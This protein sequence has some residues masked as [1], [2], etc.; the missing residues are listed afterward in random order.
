MWLIVLWLWEGTPSVHKLVCCVGAY[1]AYCSWR[2]C[3][4]ITPCVVPSWE[5]G[6][7]GSS[8]FPKAVSS[9]GLWKNFLF[10]SLVSSFVERRETICY[11]IFHPSC[12][13]VL[14]ISYFSQVLSIVRWSLFLVLG[15]FK[16]F[17]FL[18]SFSSG[19]CYFSLTYLW[20]Y[21]YSDIII[22]DIFGKQVKGE[23]NTK[24]DWDH[25]LDIDVNRCF[26][27]ASQNF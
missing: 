8:W 27:D 5:V 12:L 17:I 3:D 22:V 4:D 9:L 16:F 21:F 1:S 13:Q 15:W 11:L 24:L 7:R 2:V 23:F 14:V 26:L 25:P 20:L 19:R 6:E 10:W 18:I